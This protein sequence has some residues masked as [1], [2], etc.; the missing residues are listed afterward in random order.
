MLGEKKHEK[1]IIGGA[2]C[3]AM[4]MFSATLQVSII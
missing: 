1:S 2:N 4:L 3:A